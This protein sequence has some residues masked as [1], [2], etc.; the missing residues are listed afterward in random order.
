MYI[1]FINYQLLSSHL[2]FYEIPK[3]RVIDVDYMNQSLGHIN[4]ELYNLDIS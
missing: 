2:F 1:I 4:P 3:S